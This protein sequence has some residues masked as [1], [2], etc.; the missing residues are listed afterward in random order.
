MAGK[1]PNSKVQI[2]EQYTLLQ[3]SFRKPPKVIICGHIENPVSNQVIVYT[4]NKFFGTDL[5][6][7]MGYL[8]KAGNFR[9]EAK[10]ENKGLVIVTNPNKK[11]NIP[12][13][14]ILLYAEP[15]D[16]LYLDTPLTLKQIQEKTIYAFDPLLKANRKYMITEQISFSGDRKAEAELLYKFQEQSGLNSFKILNN[17]LLYYRGIDDVKT[18]LNALKKLEQLMNSSRKSLSSQ[19]AHYLEHELQ[20]FLYAHLI[21]APQAEREIMWPWDSNFPVIPNELKDLV[22]SQLDTLNINRIYNDYGL[23]SRNLTT[24]Y[25]RYKYNQLIPFGRR[26]KRSI[27]ISQVNDVEQNLQFNKLIL[28]GSPLYREMTNQ[29]YEYSFGPNNGPPGIFHNNLQWQRTIDETFELMIK[30]CNDEVF[31]NALKELRNTQLSWNDIRYIPAAGF[32]NLQREPSTLRSFIIEKPTIIYATNNWSVPR[33]EM[34]D[35]ASENPGINFVLI[36]GGSNYDLWKEWNDRAA[37]VAHQLFMVNDSV[38]L[39]DVFLDKINSYLVYNRSGERIGIEHDLKKAILLAKQSLETKKNEISKSTL[40][41]IIQLLS[42]FLFSI[43]VV[44]LIYK[45]RMRSRMKKQEQEKR[46]RELQMAAI[47]AQMN[48]HFLFNSLNSVQNLIQQ[49]KNQEAHLYLADFAGLIRKVLRNSDKEEVS[50]AEE[51]EMVEQYLKL[52]KLRFDFNFE[53][54]VEDGI[55]PH[56][57]MVPSIL[58][59]PFAENAVIHGLQNKLLNRQLK[60]NITRKKPGICISIEDNGIGREASQKI[61]VGNNGKSTNMIKERLAMLQEKQGEKYQFEITDLD[62]GPEKG[63]RVEILIPD[64]I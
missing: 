10:L 15:G 42:I 29:L 59:Q 40:T 44:F 24:Q 1:M 3:K 13:P 12:G 37:P 55:D 48:P 28:S 45:Y 8:D 5:D 27:E 30:R 46:L 14:V 49:N 43:L 56:N 2:S 26:L 17:K 54:N 38:R 31:I 36:N 33:Y 6:S 63:T 60:I 21:E 34:D 57:T 9:I 11:Q 62:E 16:S 22:Q 7:K 39:Q 52:E 25:V 58:L 18:Y 32:L 35:L 41:G 23:F 61:A 50:L 19:S 4:L 64:E 53:V 47:R 20:A 51:L